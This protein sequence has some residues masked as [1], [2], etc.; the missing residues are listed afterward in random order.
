LLLLNLN[1]RKLNQYTKLISAPAQM[2]NT[3]KNVARLILMCLA[4]LTSFAGQ[5]VNK[6]PAP[7]GKILEVKI[8]DTLPPSKIPL[9]LDSPTGF[10]TRLVPRIKDWDNPAARDTTRSISFSARLIGERAELKISAIGA[11]GSLEKEEEVGNYSMSVGDQI[12][13]TELRDFGYEPVTVTMKQ[14]ALT[15]PGVPGVENNMR[16]IRVTVGPRISTLSAFSFHF[17]NDSRKSVMAVA[18]RIHQAGYSLRSSQALGEHGKALMEPGGKHDM[19]V[20]TDTVDNVYGG[21]TLVIE[22]AVFED[23]TF[24]GNSGPPHGFS[25][26][27]GGT[28]ARAGAIASDIE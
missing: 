28:Q 10:W 19:T 21:V 8:V 15:P 18:W 17:T 22:S 13:T 6:D 7:T 23:G 20:R 11:K 14:V 9:R 2:Q 1:R 4:P 26:L 27:P 12:T 25:I 16:S 24:E 3:L 5:D